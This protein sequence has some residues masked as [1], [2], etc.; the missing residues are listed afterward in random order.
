MV[1]HPHFPPFF[2]RLHTSKVPLCGLWLCIVCCML[3]SI[4]AWLAASA[5]TASRGPSWSLFLPLLL[6]GMGFYF[7]VMWG[8]ISMKRPVW[9]C[10]APCYMQCLFMPGEIR[11]D[12]RSLSTC[13]PRAHTA[14][15]S[16]LY[17]L[18]LA[19]AIPIV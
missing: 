11:R 15:Y 19:G 3:Y 13:A 12:K 8:F 4:A 14:L 17:S 5:C 1:E 10:C 16:I 18:T 2:D 7:Y 9:L 6:L